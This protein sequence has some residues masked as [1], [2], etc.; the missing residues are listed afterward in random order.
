M[1][2]YLALTMIVNDKVDFSHTCTRTFAPF[3]IVIAL[4]IYDNHYN[5]KHNYLRTLHNY[6]HTTRAAIPIIAY[7]HRD[8]N[9]LRCQEYNE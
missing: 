1:Y 2:T 8:V 4:F 6:T 3:P 9:S 5:V 7:T